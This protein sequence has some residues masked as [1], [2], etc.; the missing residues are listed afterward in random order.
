MIISPSGASYC[1]VGYNSKKP[2]PTPE[3]PLGVEWPGITYAEADKPNWVGHLLAEQHAAKPSLLVFNYSLGGE[4]VFGV[5]RQIESQFLPSAGQKPDW[6]PWT[7]SDT[8]FSQF[9]DFSLIFTL[10]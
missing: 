1:Q 6:A 4:T 10:G 3:N 5:E 9:F 2:H 8:L 7:A